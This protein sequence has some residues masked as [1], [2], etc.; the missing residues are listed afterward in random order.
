MVDSMVSMKNT[1]CDYKRTCRSLRSLSKVRNK[2]FRYR[3][4]CAQHVRMCTEMLKRLE[5]LYSTPATAGQ[6]PS[7]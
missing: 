4:A 1:R 7:L 2:K 6:D 3:L 5:D